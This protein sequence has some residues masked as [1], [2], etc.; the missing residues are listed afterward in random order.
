MVL[1]MASS[2]AQ[3]MDLISVAQK[4][5]DVSVDAYAKY[6]PTLMEP[7]HMAG[8]D[9]PQDATGGSGEHNPFQNG[10]RG[11]DTPLAG[12]RGAYSTPVPGQPSPVSAQHTA[13]D[14]FQSELR[15]YVMDYAWPATQ[16]LY[17][18][19]HEEEHTWHGPFLQA[20]CNMSSS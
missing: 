2:L 14:R 13:A 15:L 4:T 5:G 3:A 8:L 9:M 10:G 17:S 16:Q 1:L 19:P 12:A 11:F 6:G 20:D 18:G 7:P